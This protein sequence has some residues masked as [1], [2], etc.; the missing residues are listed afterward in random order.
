MLGSPI[1]DLA[2]GMAFIYLLLSLIASVL[3]EIL[4][5]ITQ[6]RAANLQRGLHSLFSGDPLQIDPDGKGRKLF[7][8]ALYAHGLVRGLYQDPDQD[9][10][11][12]E[13]RRVYLWR[14]FLRDLRGKIRWVLRIEPPLHLASQNDLLLPAYIQPAPLPC[15]SSICLTTKP[16]AGTRWPASRRTWKR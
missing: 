10:R 11:W 2:I 14:R 6:A 13:S 5:T 12:V 7:V 15:L 8:D 4:A 1:L 16:M 9:T 3:Q